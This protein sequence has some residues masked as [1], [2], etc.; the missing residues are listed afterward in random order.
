VAAGGQNLVAA[1]G[2]KLQA[3][4]TPPGTRRPGRFTRNPSEFPITTTT[5]TRH[6]T[7]P[8]GALTLAPGYHPRSQSAEQDPE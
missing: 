5:L 7:Q 1:G 6:D 2:Q 8:R 3:L 4:D